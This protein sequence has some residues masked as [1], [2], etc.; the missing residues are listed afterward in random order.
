MALPVGDEREMMFV[1]QHLRDW[2]TRRRLTAIVLLVTSLLMVLPISLRFAAP[3]VSEEANGKDLSEPFPCQSR[4]CGC[5]SAK[6]CWKKCCCFT[7]TQKVAW[8]KANRVT[9]PAFVVAAAK[10]EA[11]VAKA[12]CQGAEVCCTS[13]A[14]KSVRREGETPAE[15]RAKVNVQSPKRLGRSLALPAQRPRVRVVVGIEALQCQGVEQTIAGVLISLQPPE[16]L[17]V[18]ITNLDTGE[19]WLLHDSLLAPCEQEPPTPPP[20]LGVA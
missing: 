7:D 19:V 16:L 10:R 1:V 12:A 20:R 17:T 9:L 11:P 6:Q 5:K 18:V 2:M 8:A 3:E 15:P 4:R 13:H 14:V